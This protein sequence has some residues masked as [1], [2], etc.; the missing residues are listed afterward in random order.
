M[1]NLILPVTSAGLSPVV[2][3]GI[4]KPATLSIITTSLLMV[5][6]PVAPPIFKVVASPNAFTVVAVAFIMLKDVD[7]VVILLPETS[8]SLPA[9]TSLSAT[10]SIP[11]CIFC[12]AL[13]PPVT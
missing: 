9:I 12:C 2:P 8:I 4:C 10:T 6:V 7:V 3:T 13:S 11:E 5:S 1:L